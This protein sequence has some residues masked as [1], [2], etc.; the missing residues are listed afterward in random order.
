MVLLYTVFGF[1]GGY[2]SSR[3]YKTFGGESWKL[4]ISLTPFLVP[5]IVF[6]M[7][8][9]L[10]LFLWAKGSSGAVPFTT[11]IIIVLMWFIISVP[12]SVAGSWIAFKQ[13]PIA[14]PVRTNQIPR[15]IP[16]STSYLRPVPAMLLF[17]SFPFAA[18][19]VELYF[20]MSSIWTSKVY[21]MFGFLFLCY[22][23]MTIICACVTI[24]MI[25]FLL[26]KENYHWHWRAFFTAGATAGYV[27]AYA[28]L[29]WMTKMKLGGLAGGVLYV[30]YSALISFL[31]FIL[32]G[33]V[34]SIV[35]ARHTNIAL[36]SI[37]FF[38]SWAFVHKIYGSIKID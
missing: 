3:V 6:S 37:G 23:L 17:G 4:N 25:Y 36:G 20:I 12:L 34:F 18:I 30:G 32:T 1:I 28:M 15:Q 33:K 22:G 16:P 13:S 5:G 38:S 2:V 14:S 10:N 31:C 21:Y 8:F 7:F 26:C 35:S 9:F 11:M 19:F 27:F 24:L 29:Y